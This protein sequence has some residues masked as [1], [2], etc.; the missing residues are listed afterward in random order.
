MEEKKGNQFVR[1]DEKSNW[2]SIDDGERKKE[3]CRERRKDARTKE[4]RKE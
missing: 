4:I 2:K 1:K 3:G